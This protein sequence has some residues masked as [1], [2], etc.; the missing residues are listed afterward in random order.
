LPPG[1]FDSIRPTTATVAPEAY[2]AEVHQV[3]P[4]STFVTGQD[5]VTID[6]KPV[7]R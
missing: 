2:R 1:A 7:L 5:R 4:M 3:T 6:V